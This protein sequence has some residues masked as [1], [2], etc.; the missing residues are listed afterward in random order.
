[1]VRGRSLGAYF[2]TGGDCTDCFIFRLFLDLL[3]ESFEG[4]EVRAA[5]ISVKA[6]GMR[7]NVGGVCDETRQKPSF[8]KDAAM[9]AWPALE[10]LDLDPW[11]A[12]LQFDFDV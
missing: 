6:M 2:S 9:K 12:A 11:K 3:H 5:S 1:V 10:W 7:T 8:D 4:K